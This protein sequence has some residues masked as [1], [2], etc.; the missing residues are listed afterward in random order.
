MY[1]IKMKLEEIISSF[2][3]EYFFH[4]FCDKLQLK[5]IDIY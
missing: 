3:Y 5:Y 1:V 4:K 2:M